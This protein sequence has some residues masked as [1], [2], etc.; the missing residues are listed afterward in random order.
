MQ[1]AALPGHVSS[2]LG[3]ENTAASKNKGCGTVPQLHINE[4]KPGLLV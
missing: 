4:R 2:S 1:Q 3:G